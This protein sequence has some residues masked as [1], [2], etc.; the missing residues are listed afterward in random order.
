MTPSLVKR[1]LSGA[2]SVGLLL[3]A[4]P[5]EARQDVPEIK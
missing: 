3:T 5:A 1:I 4:A 2:A